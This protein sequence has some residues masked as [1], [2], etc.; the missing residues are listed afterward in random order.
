M[1]LVVK[2][3]NRP[4]GRFGLLVAGATLYLSFAHNFGFYHANPQKVIT[5]AL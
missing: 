1:G 3:G 5:S 2:G 4:Y